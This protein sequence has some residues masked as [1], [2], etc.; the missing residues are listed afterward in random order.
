MKLENKF[1]SAFFY[2]F[3]IGIVLS[4]IIV[5]T[6]LSHYS[7]DYLDK[8]GAEDIYSIEKKYATIKI[9]SQN[10]L[11][12]NILLKIRVYLHENYLL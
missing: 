3:L 12:S 4:I 11:I 10:L 1:Y 2:P 8:K 9:N 7:N 5:A 6:I